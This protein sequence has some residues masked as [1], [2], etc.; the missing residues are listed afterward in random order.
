MSANSLL[1]DQGAEQTGVRYFK[2]YNV[3]P[4][5]HWNPQLEVELLKLREEDTTPKVL[6]QFKDGEQ[7]EIDPKG[8]KNKDIL[9]AIVA[10]DTEGQIITLGPGFLGPAYHE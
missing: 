2:Y 4:L 10:L 7:K 3:Q 6:V 8:L 1:I 5:K 9:K